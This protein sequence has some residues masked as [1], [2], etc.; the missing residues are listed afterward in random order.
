MARWWAAFFI[1][2]LVFPAHSQT[3]VCAVLFALCLALL[4]A[5]RLN[6]P[7]VWGQPNIRAYARIA[8]TSYVAITCST[9]IMIWGAA[10]IARTAHQVTVEGVGREG[11]RAGHVAP[12][13][14]R[15]DGP[16][17]NTAVDR[18]IRSLSLW[19]PRARLLRLLDDGRLSKRSRGIVGAL[20]LDDRSALDWRLSEMYSY[21]GI[22]HFLAL[23]GMHLGV[24]AIPLSK[25][26]SLAVPSRRVRDLLLFAVLCLYSAVAGFPPSLL[27]ALAL[28]A[29]AIGYR[30][31]SIHGDLSSRGH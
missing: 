28:L 27:R 15:A 19:G 24:I 29:A 11:Y 31:L 18:G 10:G 6:A 9:G 23:S 4:A 8:A 2:G 21:L 3:G 26:L 22:T 20:I 17:T 1:M 25:L 7:G 14:S 12:R 13:A 5:W 30:Q 16:T